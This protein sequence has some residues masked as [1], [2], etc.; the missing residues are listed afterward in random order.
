MNNEFGQLAFLSVIFG[1]NFS[2]RC[3]ALRANSNLSIYVF[4]S[5]K[6]L[7]SFLIIPTT[8]TYL[9]NK[10]PGDEQ[11]FIHDVLL[12]VTFKFLQIPVGRNEPKEAESK[13]FMGV[14]LVSMNLQLT[15][16]KASRTFRSHLLISILWQQAAVMYQL[17][18]APSTV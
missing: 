9:F 5:K 14:A 12:P 15:F 16:P 11:A 17:Q 4:G 8:T 2:I 7:C 3:T 13:M 18:Y 1:C 10:D 6:R